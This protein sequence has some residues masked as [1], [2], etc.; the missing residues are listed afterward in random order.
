MT[1]SQNQSEMVLDKDERKAL[2][3]ND[4]A[5]AVYRQNQAI[6]ENTYVINPEE[7]TRAVIPWVHSRKKRGIFTVGCRACATAR[8][9]TPWALYGRGLG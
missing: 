5:E 6:W 8:A 3:L 1:V 2:N 7:P 9:S 4:K